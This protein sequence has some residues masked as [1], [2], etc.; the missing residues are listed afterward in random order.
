MLRD[1]IVTARP[2]QWVKNLFVL[3]PL[4]F[5]QRLDSVPDVLR[6]LAAFGLFCLLASGAYFVNDALDAPRDRLHP[7]KARRPV[8]AG[9]IGRRAAGLV[10]LAAMAAAIGL[11]FLIGPALATVLGIYGGQNLLYS[12]L[13]KSVAMVDVMVIAIGFVLRAVAGAVAIDVPFSVWLLLCTFFVAMLMAVAKRRAEAAALGDAA[14]GTR[15]ALG[16]FNLS[17]LDAVL[18]AMAAATL[19]SY[20]LYTVS[21]ETV[22]KVGGKGLILT[23]PFVVYGVIRYLQRIFTDSSAENPTSVVLQDRGMQIAVAGWGV[24]VLVIIY[25][26]GASLGGLLE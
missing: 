10:G 21:G 9:R 13:L 12:L 14:N 11:A 24:L 4:I 19:V 25:G 6:T 20:A 8:A 5:A 16:S 2:A 22:A 17:F 18:T 3:A 26:S 23:M 7:K 1:Y 15:P